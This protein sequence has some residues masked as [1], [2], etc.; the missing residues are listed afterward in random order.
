MKRFKYL[1]WCF[2]LLAVLLSDVMCAVT[3]YGYASIET[4][5]EYGMTSA[6]PDVAF[7]WIV[8]FGA[9][10]L[11]CILIAVFCQ[12]KYRISREKKTDSC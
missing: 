12:K 8:P 4:R 9:G 10:I 6:P 2:I 11:I 1:S 7:L 5:M 3:A